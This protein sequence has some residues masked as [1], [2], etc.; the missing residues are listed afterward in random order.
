MKTRSL[1]EVFSRVIQRLDLLV[2]FAMATVFAC[3]P[4]TVMAQTNSGTI[5]N[6]ADDNANPPPK[7]S[8][9]LAQQARVFEQAKEKIRADCIQGRR[10][11][12]GRIIKI[13]PDGLIVDSGYASL[14]R[15]PLNKSWL[16][17]GTVQATREANLVE[18]NEPGC[19]CVGLVFLTTA[20]KARA[21]TPKPYDYVVIQGYPAGQ[22]TYISVGTIQRT[23][24]RFSASLANAVMVNRSAAGIEPPAIAPD[25]K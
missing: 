10:I 5:T 11:I 25:G 1:A 12:C 15:P 21:A 7:E 13:L 3:L 16:V 17:P 2:V 4:P 20:P 6:H 23:V 22:Y 24:R 8:L 18:D 14:M 9:T 19:A